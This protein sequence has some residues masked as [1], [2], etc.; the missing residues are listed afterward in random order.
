MGAVSRAAAWVRQWVRTNITG[1]KSHAMMVLDEIK[2]KPADDDWRAM[3][4]ET[5]FLPPEPLGE[6]GKVSDKFVAFWADKIVD[7]LMS[8]IV[9]GFYWLCS[10]VTGRRLLSEAQEH[11][12]QLAETFIP[13]AIWLICFLAL[14]LRRVFNS[15]KGK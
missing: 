14:T 1:G 10:K 8:L 7:F 6:D 5:K 9:A 11:N 12:Q 3:M 15:K 13:A 2:P 4:E